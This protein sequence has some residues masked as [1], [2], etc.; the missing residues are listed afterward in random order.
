MCYL[1]TEDSSSLKIRLVT[2]CQ[3]Q[4]NSPMALKHPEEKEA[5]LQKRM[6]RPEVGEGGRQK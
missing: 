5:S 6:V 4:L 2:E 3:K 1:M